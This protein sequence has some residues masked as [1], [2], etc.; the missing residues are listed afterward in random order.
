MTFR[1]RP[2]KYSTIWNRK[3]RRKFKR[4][5]KAFSRS[6]E[7][8]RWWIRNRRK[9]DL[10]TTEGFNG[11]ISEI[12]KQQRSRRRISKKYYG[13]RKKGAR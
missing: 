5:E 11:F 10:S 8:E 6:L 12:W 4:I 1:K 13:N 2:E 9:Y 7:C 3:K